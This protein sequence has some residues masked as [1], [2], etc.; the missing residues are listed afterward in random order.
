[1]KEVYKKPDN[2]ILVTDHPDF[3][4]EIDYNGWK[5][6]YRLIHNDKKSAW[7]SYERPLML[8]GMVC[9]SPYWTEH[10]MHIMVTAEVACEKYLCAAEETADGEKEEA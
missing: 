3:K 5:E 4:V 10:D 7:G 9:V 1:M 8:D 2:E 6:R